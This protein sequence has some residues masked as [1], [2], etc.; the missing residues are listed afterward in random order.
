LKIPL[1]ALTT[2]FG[3][4]QVKGQVKEFDRTTTTVIRPEFAR[5]LRLPTGIPLQLRYDANQ[6]CLVF[7]PFIGIL[8]SRY[9]LDQRNPYGTFTPFLNEIADICQQRGGIA[10][11]FRLH[12]VNWET[13]TVR[14]M[15]RRNGLWHAVTLPLPQCIYNRL[16]NRKSDKSDEVHKWI[17]RC[18]E[19]QIPVFNEHFL[20]KWHV[21]QALQQQPDAMPYLPKTILYH[22]HQDLLEMFGSYASVYAKPTNGSMGKGIYLI[23]AAANGYKLTR[24]TVTGTATRMFRDLMSLHRYL[25]KETKGKKYL[26]QQGLSLIGLGGKPADF[27]V[28]VQKDKRGEWS[29]SSL[30][31]RL[32]QNKVVSNIARGGSMISPAR[33]LHICGPKLSGPTSVHSL[34]QVALRL[35]R[36]LEESI[37]GHYAEFGIDLGVDTRGRIW[38]LEVNSKPSKAT[39][40]VQQQRNEA[41]EPIISRRPRPSVVRMLDYAAYLCGFPHPGSHKRNM[42]AAKK[43]IRKRR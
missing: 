21:H 27:R 38:L 28:L 40:S 37:Q 24:P 7:G 42:L 14:G 43:R 2:Q 36:Q 26:L 32:G 12:D 4:M 15:I 25:Q 34:K 13:E 17:L 31:A 18:K 9:T 23:R 19:R 35:A 41:G 20:N 5:S 8:V 39:S 3:S 30:V 1:T 11:A 6:Q 29:V 10:I 22:A 16:G 33:A